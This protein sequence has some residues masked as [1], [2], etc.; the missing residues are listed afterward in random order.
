MANRPVLVLEGEGD[1]EAVPYLIRE[2]TECKI[3]PTPNPFMK[4]T[5]GCLSREGELERF[6]R[7]ALMRNDADSVLFL[8]DTDEN[9]AKEIIE[10]WVPRLK[11]LRPVRKVGIG[12][13]VRE[14]EAFFLACLDSIADRYQNYGWSLDDWD[15]TDDHESP[16]GAKERITRYMRKGRAYKETSDQARFVSAVDFDRLRGHC[17]SFRHLEN[18]LNWLL[19]EDGENVYP[20]NPDAV[21]VGE[22]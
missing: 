11:E 7:Y 13:F 9:C 15:V 22:C 17:R 14:F 16:R 21:Q 3:I 20:L 2:L 1:R 10:D 12:L 5:I 8:V 4:Q 19:E 18:L 6:T